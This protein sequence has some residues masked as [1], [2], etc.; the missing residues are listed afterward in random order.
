MTA[1][2]TPTTTVTVEGDTIITALADGTVH[3]TNREEWMAR[4]PDTLTVDLWNTM[5]DE[6]LTTS[7]RA[8]QMREAGVVIQS[9]EKLLRLTNVRMSGGR[10]L[11]ATCHYQW[12]TI[13]TGNTYAIRDTLKQ[14]GCKWDGGDRLWYRPFVAGVSHAD[15]MHTVVHAVQA[16]LGIM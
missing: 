14:L 11:D 12:Q 15:N 9:R 7:R 4:K 5:Y 1:A 2:T 10:L 16:A 8:Q 3:V 6:M 13:I